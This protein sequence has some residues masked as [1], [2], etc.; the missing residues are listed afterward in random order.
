[1]FAKELPSGCGLCG[2]KEGL[3]QCSG[4]K[5]LS[6]CG[7]AHRV[8]D[9]PAHKSACSAIRKARGKMEKQEQKLR[10]HPDIMPSDPFVDHV[11]SFWGVHEARPYM[12]ARF[13]L[14]ESMA[15]IDNVQSVEA[16][17]D[18]V[19]D[20]LR[21]CRSDNMGVRD[22]VP[23]LLLRLNKD[24]ECYNFIKWWQVV[25]GDPWYDWGKPGLPS[26]LDITNADIFEPMG[27]PD[28]FG[29]L[30]PFPN[31]SHLVCLCLLK[32]K[33]LFDVMRLKQSTAS[34]G[35]VVP[36]EILDLIQSSVP[37]SPAVRASHDIMFGDNDVRETMIDKLKAQIDVIFDAV[38][39]ANKHFWPALLDP[40]IDLTEI[41]EEY[42]PSS[43]E[44]MI[45]V[46]RYSRD[47]WAETPGAIDF[48]QAKVFDIFLGMGVTL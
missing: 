28:S 24:Q 32:I 21:L 9:R 46:L 44:E 38:Q 36:R 20:M 41:P 29:P 34:L 18:H 4:C 31:V 23:G 7:R 25:S 30:T 2:Q 14:V 19:M 3:L 48:I 12:R 1:M 45:L 17:L 26:Y 33:F 22:L 35:P 5:V 42:G 27:R 37:Q 39:D 47:A 10:N 13:A 16:Q 6:Y 15:E 8:A 40:D 43:V 11:G